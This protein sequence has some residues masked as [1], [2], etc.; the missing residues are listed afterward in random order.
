MRFRQGVGRLIRSQTDVGE[1]VILDS[2]ILN[3]RYGKDFI[4]E[5]PNKNFESTC[6]LDLIG[7]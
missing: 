4:E 2:R 5:L 1:L 7:C 6:L 3:K